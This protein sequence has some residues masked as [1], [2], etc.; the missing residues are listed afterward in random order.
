MNN[1]IHING[2]TIQKGDRAYE[3]MDCSGYVLYA[4]PTEQLAV[5]RTYAELYRAMSEDYEMMKREAGG[6]SI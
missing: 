1:T 2:Y 5:L 3:I 6:V 4:E